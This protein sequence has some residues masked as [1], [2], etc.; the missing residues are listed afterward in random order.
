MHDSN[1]VRQLQ[2]WSDEGFC[3]PEDDAAVGHCALWCEI[4]PSVLQDAFDSTD[5]TPE[6]EP[7]YGD[8]WAEPDEQLI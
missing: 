1:M 3:V 2:P 8:F 6:P 5:E 7:E 4:N